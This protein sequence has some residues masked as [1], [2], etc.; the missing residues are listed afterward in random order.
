[1]N[2]DKHWLII[3]E[4]KKDSGRSVLKLSKERLNINTG[5]HSIYFLE[6]NPVQLSL[7]INGNREDSN[8]SKRNTS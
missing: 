3:N 2:H 4:D 1:M 5:L 7:L 8:H 6:C